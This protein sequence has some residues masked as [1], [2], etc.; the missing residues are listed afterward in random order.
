[1]ENTPIH[2]TILVSAIAFIRMGNTELRSSTLDSGTS[3]V[4][5]NSAADFGVSLTTVGIT[6]FAC[7]SASS[8]LTFSAPR[9]S[10]T[11]T[12]NYSSFVVNYYSRGSKGV[13]VAAIKATCIEHFFHSYVLGK[14]EIISNFRNVGFAAAA[15]HAT[16]SGIKRRSFR[17][18]TVLD[19]YA[20]NVSTAAMAVYE[21][22]AI[23]SVSGCFSALVWSRA[24]GRTS[25]AHFLAIASCFPAAK[26][27]EKAG[28]K[29]FI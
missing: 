29:P 17:S 7:P 12:P 13:I 22:I 24:D 25:T 18:G 14:A 8:I 11:E 6:A 9:R 21:E 5:C 28:Q 4:D 15:A 2:G 16:S 26:P 10:A 20:P 23:I 1:M 27:K 3:P 19:D